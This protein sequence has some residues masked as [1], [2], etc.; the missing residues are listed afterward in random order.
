MANVWEAMKKHDAEQAEQVEQ[1]GREVGAP[2]EKAPKPVPGREN[3]PVNAK[4]ISDGQYSELLVV[5]HDRGGAITEEY[6]SLRNNL[7]AQCPSDRFCYLITSSDPGEGKTVTCLNLALVMA[8]RVDCR[9]VVIDCDLRKSR[10]AGLLGARSS[11][12]VAELLRGSVSLDE[13][14]QPVCCSNLFFIPA[15]D[16]RHDETGEL[17][18]RPELD[19]FVGELRRQ[20]DYVIFDTPPM[21]FA[22][23]AGTLGKVV[24]E[25]LLVVKMNK[26]RR[27]SVEKTIRLLHAA[28]VKLSGIILTHRKY[29]IPNYIYRYS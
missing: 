16:V 20:Y 24:D 12:G 27:E 14:V 9:T 21:N 5:Y 3:A 6:R 17:I 19:E 25:A 26:T 22:S 1:A 4:I 2:K 28:N 29:Y 10:M 18:G 13:C 7:L 11:P 15:G 8:E 23:D